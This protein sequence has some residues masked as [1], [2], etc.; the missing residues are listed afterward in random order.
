MTTPPEMIHRSEAA[1]SVG[2]KV[3]NTLEVTFGYSV[4]YVTRAVFAGDI[5]DTTINPTRPPVS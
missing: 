1:V 3:T 4:I 5:I 2:Y